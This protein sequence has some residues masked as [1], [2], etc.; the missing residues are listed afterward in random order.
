M[1]KGATTKCSHPVILRLLLIL[2]SYQ[3][4]KAGEFPRSP[5]RGVGALSRDLAQVRKFPVLG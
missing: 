2:L 3:W 4:T 5:W 1:E